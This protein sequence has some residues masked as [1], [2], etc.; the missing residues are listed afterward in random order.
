MILTCQCIG[1]EMH[2]YFTPAIY[3]YPGGKDGFQASEKAAWHPGCESQILD[4]LDKKM[5]VDFCI[6]ICLYI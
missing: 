5:L 6:L 3:F 1:Q 2:H 4:G